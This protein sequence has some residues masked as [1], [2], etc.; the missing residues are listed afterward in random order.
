MNT[1]EDRDINKREWT[2][3]RERRKIE[4]TSEPA[5]TEQGKAWK[6]WVEWTNDP[7]KPPSR[8]KKT[9]NL[10]NQTQSPLNRESQQTLLYR[11]STRNKGSGF[12]SLYL[13]CEVRLRSF[14]LWN[15][16]LL[17]MSIKNRRSYKKIIHK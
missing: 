4:E 1:N 3:K 5:R 11:G 17:L 2:C 6:I 15:I 12:C 16:I 7:I 14:W 9:L 10:P 8:V 13:W